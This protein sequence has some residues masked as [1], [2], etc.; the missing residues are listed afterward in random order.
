MRQR[1]RSVCARVAGRRSRQ[2]SPFCDQ[3]GTSLDPRPCGGRRRTGRRAPARLGALRRP[4]RLHDALR[5][6]DAEEVRELLSRYFDSVRAIIERYGGTVEKFIGDAVMAVWGTPVAHED[7]A[8][9]AVRAGL[10]SSTR[11]RARRRARRAEL[12]ARAGVLTGEVAVTVGADGAG[13]GRR[14]HR[15]HRLARPVGGRAGHG[16]RRRRDAARDRGG[17][18]VRGRRRARAEGQDGAGAGCGARCASSPRARRAL[19]A[20]GL[21]PPF[22]GRERELAA[23]QG[24]L[25][26]LRGGAARAA[27]VGRRRSPG[28]A[29]RGCVGVREVRRRARRRRS[30]GT[31]AAASPT[32]RASP[33]GRWPRWCACAPASRGRAQPTTRCAK[34]ARVARRASSPTPDERAL[35]RAAPRAPARPRR[36]QRSATRRTCSPRGG[37]SSSAWPTP[38]PSCSSSRTCSG[39]TRHCS[40]SSSTC[41]SGRAN[42]PIFVLALARPELAERRPAWGAGQRSSTSLTSNRCRAAMHELLGGLVPA[43]RTSCTARILERAEGVP[44]YA[45]ETVRMLLDRAS[46]CATGD[47]YRPPAP[48]RRSRSRRRSTRWSPRGSTGS[49]PTERRCSR[50]PRCSARRSRGKGLA[51]LSGVFRANSSSR[52][53]QPRAQGGPH[54]A[55]RSALARAWPI[56]VPAGPGSHGSPTRRSMR[57]RKAAA[58]RRR[59]HIWRA[60]GGR[61]RARR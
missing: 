49:S 5:A 24:A 56:R 13:H 61:G 23:D 14:R 50:T 21:E 17:D 55:G 22:V 6:R 40:T 26:R 46:S 8:E 59:R 33:T 11:C 12:R 45:V 2:D 44:L 58:S 60:R 15:Q 48:S 36:A 47:V 41:S 20:D 32:A 52:C 10:D 4:R 19:A 38:S 53:S 3:C 37:C 42:H 35:R 16:P 43:C 25:P 27:R 34:L 54:G 31:A 57:E 39:R 51:A 18:R 30:A 7:D 28:S 1:P 29:S 9:R